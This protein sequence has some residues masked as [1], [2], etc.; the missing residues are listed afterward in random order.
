M[1]GEEFPALIPVSI[2]AVIIVVGF[3]TLFIE[4]V[5]KVQVLADHRAGLGIVARLIEDVVVP[6]A[7]L[8]AMVIVSSLE[9][10]VCVVVNDTD[11]GVMWNS[12]CNKNYTTVVSLPFLIDN[13]SLN[14]T[15]SA[16]ASV[17]VLKK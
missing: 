4:D 3:A 9:Y 7:D 17:K 6:Q 16:M 12:S 13:S 14:T 8:P 15:F 5:N 2:V 1:I 11:R 10:D